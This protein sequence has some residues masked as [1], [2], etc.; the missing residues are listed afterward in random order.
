MAFVP[1]GQADRSQAR[2]AWLCS[3][4]FR[5]KRPF[6]F[7][8]RANLMLSDSATP[9]LLTKCLRSLEYTIRSVDFNPEPSPL[10]LIMQNHAETSQTAGIDRRSFLKS[11]AAGTAAFAAGVSLLSLARPAKAAGSLA[12][13]QTDAAKAA[14]ELAKGWMGPFGYLSA[15]QSWILFE[16]DSMALLRASRFLAVPWW[17][18]KYFV[19]TSVSGAKL[20]NPTSSE[21][22][23]SRC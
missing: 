20:H 10:P 16:I 21:A 11:A 15:L 14:K 8:F 4:E 12:D 17:G 13:V 6:Q 1:E 2:S 5:S 9:E 19:I 7:E 23:S 18:V 3:L 22:K